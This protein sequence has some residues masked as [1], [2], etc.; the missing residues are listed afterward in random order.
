MEQGGDLQFFPFFGLASF[1]SEDVIQL[2]GQVTN[3]KAMEEPAV[4]AS[5]IRLVS[6][7]QLADI[8]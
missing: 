1:A 6:H 5:R 8:P 3:P 4:F 2:P 7:S